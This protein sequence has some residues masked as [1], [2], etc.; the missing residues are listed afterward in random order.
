[1]KIDAQARRTIVQHEVPRSITRP[2]QDPVDPTLD[3][4]DEQRL[5]V[6]S[7]N[8]QV[9]VRVLTRLLAQQRID[10]PAAAHARVDALI[11]ENAEQSNRRLG[12]HDMRAHLSPLLRRLASP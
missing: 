10:G 4:S 9:T 1:M 5:D 2:G 11:A 6:S 12:P 8:P 3:K 7:R